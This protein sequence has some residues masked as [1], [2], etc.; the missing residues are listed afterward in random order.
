MICEVKQYIDETTGG[1]VIA[2]LD[3][4][5]EEVISYTGMAQI[6]VQTPQGVQGMP[7][8][9]DIEADDIAE[10]FSGFEDAMKARLEEMQAEQE[11][12]QVEQA[13]AIV[14]IDG[15]PLDGKAK[16]PLEFPG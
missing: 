7:I 5:S 13:G 14:G 10:A 12:A 16:G 1:M 9:F 3:A 8:E 2:K 6:P 4:I 15:Q 11:K